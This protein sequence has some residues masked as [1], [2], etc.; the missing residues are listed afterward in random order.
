[1]R[2]VCACMFG[3]HVNHVLAPRTASACVRGTDSQEFSHCHTHIHASNVCTH[4]TEIY[5]NIQAHTCNHRHITQRHMCIYRHMNA[6]P[7]VCISALNAHVSA[8]ACRELSFPPPLPYLLTVPSLA[9]EP[10]VRKVNVATP[11][12][13]LNPLPTALSLPRAASEALSAWACQC[14]SPV[15]PLAFLQS[16]FSSWFLPPQGLP[17]WSSL[18]PGCFSCHPFIPQLPLPFQGAHSAS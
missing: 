12:P 3:S 16:L 2:A 11:Y 13:Q 5:T 14:A 10:S 18:G 8:Q 17:T 4:S 7:F 1:M 15:C 6:A 9:T